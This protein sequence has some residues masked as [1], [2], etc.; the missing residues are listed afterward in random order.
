MTG[1]PKLHEKYGWKE[2]LHEEVKSIRDVVRRQGG[3]KEKA[4][5][6]AIA[7]YRKSLGVSSDRNASYGGNEPLE[8]VH[9]HDL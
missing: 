9:V 3:I 4:I 7:R 8:E 1:V 6:D 5:D 2:Q